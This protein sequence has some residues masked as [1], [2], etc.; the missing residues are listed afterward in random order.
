MY[1]AALQEQAQRQRQSAMGP[2]P[3]AS[4][5]RL[6]VP[7]VEHS[8]LE[9]RGSVETVGSEVSGYEDIGRGGLGMGTMKGGR[10]PIMHSTRASS[11]V[12]PEGDEDSEEE[13]RE[14]EEIERAVSKGKG[15]ERQGS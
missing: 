8:G 3:V 13:E 7:V 6:G 11:G 5:S 4:G 15:N 9:E 1:H 12:F 14:R 10:T 2:L